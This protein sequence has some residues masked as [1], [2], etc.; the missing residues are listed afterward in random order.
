MIA[1]PINSKKYGEKMFFIDAEDFEIVM[2]KKWRLKRSV[3]P[4][5]ENFYVISQTIGVFPPKTI[6]LHRYLLNCP[7]DKI[8][9]H[10]DGNTMNYCR[11][12][13]RICSVTDNNRNR[14]KIHSVYT[15]E[16]KGVSYVKER[17]N[18]LAQIKLSD[19]RKNLGRYKTEIEAARAYDI[20]ARKN[21]G[22]F[23]VLNFPEEL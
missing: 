12:N 2:Q 7:P 19:H 20:C 16:Y 23:A 8:V 21:F 13:L 3:S 4:N 18:W 5:T 14:K 17:G 11:N 22:E 6:R 9:D 10:A 1:I 15:S